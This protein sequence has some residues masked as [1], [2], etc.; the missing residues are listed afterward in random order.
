M[1]DLRTLYGRVATLIALPLA[2]VALLPSV[3]FGI[4]L[5]RQNHE[6][7]IDAA[8]NR[9]A[10]RSTV[11]DGLKPLGYA[12]ADGAIVEKGKPIDYYRTHEAERQQALERTRLVLRRF[13]SV[14]C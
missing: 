4:Y 6:R 7:C 8:L 10:I 9:E 5:Q 1:H 3:I 11:I 13:P 14:T 2:L 12:Y